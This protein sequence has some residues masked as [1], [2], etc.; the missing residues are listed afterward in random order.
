M[1]RKPVPRRPRVALALRRQPRVRTA[2]VVLVGLVSGSAVAATVQQADDTRAAWGQSTVVVVATRDLAAGEQVD[3]RN[4]NLVEHPDPLVPEGALTARPIDGRLAEAVYAGEVVRKKRLAGA[5][6]SAL[7]A[8]LPAGTRAVAIPVEPGWAPTLAIGDHVDVL[9]A[10]PAEASG[11]GPPGFAL[12][13]DVVVVDVGD[14]S[15]TV[16][17]APDVA[18]RIAVAFG[19]GAITLALVGPER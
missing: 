3:S 19:Q 1:R 14:A 18:P 6:L 7:A 9:V 5:G 15:V 2:L 4:T 13:T 11:G 10:L 17:V 12:A 16:A 8:R